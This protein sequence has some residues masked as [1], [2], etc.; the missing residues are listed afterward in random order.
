[1][2]Q[3]IVND[4]QSYKIT[5][6]RMSDE[7]FMHV[8]AK[9]ARTGIQ[10]Y[11]ARELGLPGDPNR[12]VKVMRPED[13]VFDD[14][15]LQSFDGTDVTLDHPP[16]FV[17]SKNYQQY[18]RGTVKGAGRRD[19]DWI[20]CNLV[21]KDNAAIR[22]IQDG[23]AEVSVGYSSMYDDNVPEGADYEFVQRD[24]RVNH[25]AIVDRARAGGLARIYDHQRGQT[26]PV[27]ITTD[28]GREIDAANPENASLVADAYD[29]ATKR[30]VDA[31]AI[32]EALKAK[33]D[34]Q[35]EQITALKEQTSDTAIAERVSKIAKAT[36]DARKI[37]GEKFTSDSL[38]TLEIQRAALTVVRPKIQWADKDAAY[39]QAAFDMALEE[40]AE[41]PAFRSQMTRLASDASA[42]PV[43]TSD[44]LIAR[45]KAERSNAWKGGNK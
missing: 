6:R 44:Q 20:E 29:R 26:M 7:G 38:D 36:A 9:V 4:R 15:Y 2:L 30:A 11:L 16:E 19:G 13:S 27:M 28:S 33:V 10:E 25:V 22:A 3:L 1:M 17:S 8:P 24:M 45:V 31:E 35:N 39:V 21:V 23:K 40:P 41:D 37:A 43:E 12:I 32:T 34:S 5:H 18:S 14:A 42:K